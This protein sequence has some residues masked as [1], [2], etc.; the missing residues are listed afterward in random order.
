MTSNSLS[1][2]FLHA[3]SEEEYRCGDFCN[4]VDPCIARFEPICNNRTDNYVAMAPIHQ[5]V[6]LNGRC[7]DIDTITQIM[8]AGN[9]RTPM[10]RIKFT[11]PELQSSDFARFLRDR[12]LQ[13]QRESRAM[14]V[15][16]ESSWSVWRALRAERRELENT[17]LARGI[18]LDHY[19]VYEPVNNNPHIT[20]SSFEEFRTFWGFDGIFGEE[21]SEEELEEELTA[22]W[23]RI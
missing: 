23:R 9:A 19:S 10:S 21:E 8:A 20:E 17:A 16:S 1:N 13:L 3:D 6:C 15:D 11:F 12:L 4:D 5:G 7:Y 18:I 14:D 2:T 22:W